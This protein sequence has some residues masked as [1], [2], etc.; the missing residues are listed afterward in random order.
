MARLPPDLRLVSPPRKVEIRAT[1][2][3]W[4]EWRTIRT[5]REERE[6]LRVTALEALASFR[7]LDLIPLRTLTTGG[8]YYSALHRPEDREAL[9]RWLEEE[10]LVEGW[11][12]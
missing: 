8:G 12:S 2:V 9:E 1:D 10:P 4:V 6:Q 5:R 7:R 3:L 11:T